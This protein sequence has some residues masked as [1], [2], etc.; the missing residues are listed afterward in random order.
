[1]VIKEIFSFGFIFF[2]CKWEL[3]VINL[4]LVC[5]YFG[6]KSYVIRILLEIYVL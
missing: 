6:W 5:S 2:F 4:V 1:M 3:K